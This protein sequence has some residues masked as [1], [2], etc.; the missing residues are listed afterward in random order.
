MLISRTWLS[1]L[2]VDPRGTALPDGAALGDLITGLGLEV[3]GITRHGEGLDAI[4]VGEVRSVAP[5]PDADKLRVV[6][7]LD[8]TQTLTVVCGAPNVPPPGGKVAFAPVGATLPG[9]FSI[10]ARTV[11][12]VKSHG[13]ICSEQELRIGPDHDGI[14]VLP[15]AWSAGERLVDRVPGIADTIYELGVT[16]NRPD[17]LGHIG[18]ARDLA[19]KLGRT[20][21]VP[22]LAEPKVAELPELV[23]LRAPERCGCYLGYALE[24]AKVGPSPLWLRVRLH[25]LGLR[26]INNVVDITNLVLMEWGQP[27]HAFD[28]ARLAEG[29]VVVRLASAGEA[30]TTLDEQALELRADDLVIADAQAPQALAGV[31]GGLSSGVSEASTALLLEAAW[32]SPLPIRRTAKHHGLLTDSSYR[33]ERGVDH[34]V[35][36]AR[37]A[38]RA[39]G[40]LERLTGARCVGGHRVEGQRPPVPAIALRPGR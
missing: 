18:V 1:E 7:L 37:A 21:A 28:R 15:T 23:T 17:A 38:K 19:V 5:H 32:F 40:L 14:M 26:P 16:P 31:M 27:L 22:P 4:V 6:E 25:R 34:G 12:G 29:R 39:L 3:E 11:R 8:G 24:G 2:L 13:M 35:G 20:L 33:F 30:M 9:D 36:L 10:G